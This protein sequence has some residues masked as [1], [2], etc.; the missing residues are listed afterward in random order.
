MCAVTA[1]TDPSWDKWGPSD[2]TSAHWYGPAKF[3]RLIAGYIAH[4]QDHGRE[5]TVRELITEFR[6]FRGSAS[7]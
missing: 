2:P 1:T 7:F 6:G 3:E 4:G 5:R